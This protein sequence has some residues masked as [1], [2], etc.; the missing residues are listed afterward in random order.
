MTVAT[1]LV[2]GD[3]PLPGLAEQAVSEALEKS[4]LTH[5]TGVLLF[6]TPEF[7][8]HA[9][10]VVT[11][12]ART[13]RCTQVAGGIASGV[14]TE[15]GWAVDRPAVAAMVLGGG[16][17]LGHPESGCELEPPILSYAGEHFPSEWRTSGTRFGASFN[18]NFSGVFSNSAA[19]PEPLV[20]QQSRLN[21]QQ[22]CSVQLL[23]AHIEIAVSCGLKLIDG[24]QPVEQSNGF[25]LERLGGHPALKSLVRALPPELRNRPPHH[26]HQFLAVVIDSSG[27]A[28]SALTEGC[29]RP[30]A[31][32]A[33]NP[34]QSLTLAEHVEPGQLLCWAIR[35]PDSTEV[36]MRDTLDR[37]IESRRT[38]PAPV[39][40]LVFSCIGR[41]PYFY[42]GNDRD[43]DAICKRFP[44][45]PVLGTYSTGQIAPSNC[46]H[47]RSNRP[48]QNSVVTALV[49]PTSKEANVQ[50]IA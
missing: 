26:L 2:S 10:Q 1:A 40:A 42:G 30:I 11:A 15:A 14:F 24:P 9:Q 21:E 34:D 27:E 38:R 4:G 18:G 16:L 49:S 8:R 23:G 44:G 17:S 31:I 3:E 41:G 47:G 32:I 5:A 33:A 48:L 37:L 43:L 20:W 29:F 13:A 22:R 39:C 6:L 25:D 50:S 19:H 45:L 7:A 46:S 36:E 28:E 12:A 35:Q